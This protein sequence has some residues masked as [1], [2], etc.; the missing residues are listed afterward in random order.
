MK[1]V[2][3]FLKNVTYL[4]VH[5][6]ELFGYYM[7]QVTIFIAFSKNTRNVNMHF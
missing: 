1:L 6:L 3:K 7:F 4:L 5:Y 2:P